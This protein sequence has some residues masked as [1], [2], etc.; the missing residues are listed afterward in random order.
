MKFKND[1]RICPSCGSHARPFIRDCQMKEGLP[2]LYRRRIC[3][4]CGFKWSTFEI[5]TEE[6][7][8]FRKMAE[9]M[10]ETCSKFDKLISE[11]ERDIDREDQS[12]EEY[13]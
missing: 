3:K 7:K 12:G 8:T 2:W 11:Y 13:Y 6:I 10:N 9:Q 1:V 4:E 5:H